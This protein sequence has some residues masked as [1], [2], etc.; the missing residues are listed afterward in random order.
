MQDIVDRLRLQA[1]VGLIGTPEDH[2]H[3]GYGA[4]ADRIEELEA[5]CLAYLDAFDQ[6]T[7]TVYVEP[8]IR[9]VMKDKTIASQ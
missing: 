3:V 8:I 6:A 2:Q 4:A 1:E 9:E 7:G 5:A